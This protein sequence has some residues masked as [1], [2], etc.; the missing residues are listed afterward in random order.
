[1][2]TLWFKLLF[3]L[4]ALLALPAAHAAISCTSITS[5]GVSMFYPANST[6]TV[7][8]FFTVSCTRTSTADATSIN[9][10]VFAD[11]GKNAQGQTNRATRR[12][13]TLSYDFYTDSACTTQWT[14]QTAVADKITWAAGATG[15]LTRQTAYWG[16]ITIAQTPA[17]SGVYTDQV[18]L[19]LVY[20]GVN[21]RNGTAG[22]A[23]QTPAV[24][25][26]V[27]GP[28][29]LT[30]PYAAFGAQ[31]VRSTTFRVTCTN[32]MPYT[33]GTD[34]AEGVLSGVRY[35]LGLS[36]GS[37]NGSGAPQTYTLT[38]TAPAGQAGTCPTGACTGTRSH[39]LTI[40]Y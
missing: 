9:Y 38:A 35:Q 37:A 19:T 27:A 4:G 29:D 10:S 30:L 7:Q 17:S 22:V 26:V 24:C 20:G 13:T 23:I 11:D 28:G 34:V 39:T 14:G 6:R 33:L 8:A 25:S 18:Q 16:C 3:V 1:M 32:G 15:T 31:I 2:K 5:P 36:A 12:G 21:T 40:S